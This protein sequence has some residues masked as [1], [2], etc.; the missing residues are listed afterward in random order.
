ML[1]VAYIARERAGRS[2]ATAT[3]TPQPQKAPRCRRERATGT[4]FEA[5]FAPS[6]LDTRTHLT[7]GFALGL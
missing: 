6:G 2:Y 1:A 4:A 3:R 5:N 7:Q